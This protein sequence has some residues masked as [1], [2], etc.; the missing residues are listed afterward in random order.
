MSNDSHDWYNPLSYE[1]VIKYYGEWTAMSIH[2]GNGQYTLMPPK[3]DYRLRR[4][5][6]IVADLVCKPLNQIRVLDLA[7]LEGH[8]GLEFACHGAEVVGIEV[9]EASLAKAQFAKH[10][11]HLENFNLYQDNVRN[12]SEKKYG[13]FD[14]V[15]CSG[16][17]YHLD[18]PDVFQFVKNIYEVCNHIVL[19]DTF[20]SL[21]DRI[22][23]EFESKTYWG[24]RRVEYGENATEEWKKQHLW[25][26]I[27]NNSS[28]WLTQPSLGNLLINVGFTSFYECHLPAWSSNLID[29]KTYVAIKGKTIKLISSPIT[30]QTP[31][32]EIPEHRPIDT[33]S[34][35][36][37]RNL[38]LKFAKKMFPQPIK[39]MIKS[40]LR[41]LRLMKPD[42]TPK[43][44]KEYFRTKKK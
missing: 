17:L 38:F 7:C 2:L 4:L 1:Q 14:V 16:I 11:L 25:G 5:T 40:I 39:D 19:I 31:Q 42:G 30:D 29:R 3:V 22:S 21:S 18:A 36:N 24:L 41:T 34:I 6:Q 37:Q 23:T 13:T 20:I 9:R 32:L 27:D 33:H 10:H 15:I 35:N 26:S 12:L 43:Y 28:F 8:Y 44:I